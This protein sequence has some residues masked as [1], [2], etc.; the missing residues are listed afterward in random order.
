MTA[1][2]AKEGARDDDLR[3]LARGTL[4]VLEAIAAA[5]RAG[6]RSDRNLSLNSLASA[7][8]M[9]FQNAEA[10]LGGIARDLAEENA[11]LMREPAIARVIVRDEHDHPS[12]YFIS[13]GAASLQSSSTQP[14]Y[15]N[16]PVQFAS[17]RAQ[18]GRLAEVGIG[19]TVQ[20]RRGGKPVILEVVE[21]AVLH[22]TESEGGWDSRDTVH[23][24]AGRPTITIR[25]LLR[26]LA[27][28]VEAED[29][30][31]EIERLQAEFEADKNVVIGRRRR[32]VLKKMQ[33]RDQA[34][35][36][37]Y[38]GEVFR[39]PINSQL[40]LLGSP[41]TGK[42]TTLI[43]RLGQKLGY[44]DL[45]QAEQTVIDAAASVIPHERS[46]LMFTPTDLLQVYLKEAFAREG[47]P[48]SNQLIR[49][50]T[51]H[52]HDL[53]RNTFGLLRTGNGVGPFI[54]RDDAA[55]LRLEAADQVAWYEDFNEWQVGRFWSV[56]SAA[57]DALAAADASDLSGLGLRLQTAVGRAG[58]D[59]AV[60]TLLALTGFAAEVRS[61]L[62]R[63]SGEIDEALRRALST[64][65]RAEPGFFGELM[66]FVG[67]LSER[68]DR[69]DDDVD[70]D[71]EADG[72]DE[73][74]VDPRQAG[75]A[76]A[77]RLYNSALRLQARQHVSRRRG[78][79]GAPATVLEWLGDRGLSQEE[80]AEV[81]NRLVV[82]QALRRFTNP[83]SGFVRGVPG[84]YSRFRRARR[85]DGRWYQ[86][87]AKGRLVSPFEIDV[88]LLAILRAAGALL[89][90][91][92][93]RRAQG[94]LAFA[95][96]QSVL[97]AQRNQILVD[98]A[99][100]FSPVQ[101]A[102]MRGLASAGTASFFACGDFNQRITPWGSRTPADLDWIQP[103]IDVRR[104]SVSYRQSR[105]L[106]DFAR[107]LA[108]HI[109]ADGE[110][111]LP[112][113]VDNEAVLPAL[114]LG[115]G[116]DEGVASWLAERLRE[117]ER[118]MTHTALPTVAV[119]VPEEAAVRPM[120]EA[121]N[122]ALSDRNLHA[123][124]CTDGKIIGD[125]EEIR[126]FDVQHIKGLEFEAVFFVAVDR[127]AELHPDLFDKFLYVGATR[128]ATYLGITA[129][130]T[131]PPPLLGLTDSF[132]PKW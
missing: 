55:T 130:G 23:E 42:T 30:L 132:V 129:A 50:W 13:R 98:E 25:S 1:T 76:A 102:C 6:L 126:V 4:N 72:E 18:A 131:L 100:D 48:A 36:D 115:V 79:R 106:H 88:V 16:V 84:R 17:Y 95:A 29:P 38:Q 120:T 109:G 45:E 33:L 10:V 119:L 69:P 51:I 60:A 47:V 108:A 31:A 117:I 52:R 89:A 113:D 19:G 107:E 101:L 81:G 8:A 24:A 75:P 54:M 96:L 103:G 125:D 61:A 105:Q 92:R 70:L 67:S 94:E 82:Q 65:M 58:T 78:G 3:G 28:V 127:L 91:A 2:V 124:A 43:R 7:N 93:V 40:V 123:V 39:L 34:A 9:T 41:G 71:D 57:A 74:D 77:R 121:L 110:T 118:D 114:L 83:V 26:L 14:G 32:A 46:W 116:S 66:T 68:G 86:D 99:T 44:F 21:R 111:I 63:L 97:G 87:A 22:P 49:T 15:E 62:D 80:R 59:G 27:D 5:A 112:P 104:V 20:V 12:I 85:G 56:L 128:A 64:R 73:D 37:E 122:R 53:A 35:L 90:D 11:R